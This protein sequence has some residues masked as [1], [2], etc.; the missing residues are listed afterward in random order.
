VGVGALVARSEAEC[1][2]AEGERWHSA[3][4][5]LAAPE[6]DWSRSDAKSVVRVGA[7]H[8]PRHTA[9]AWCLERVASRCQL[10]L[11]RSTERRPYHR[12]I[13]R[14]EAQ[15]GNLPFDL[16]DIVS[17]GR[18][19]ATSA[20]NHVAAHP[21]TMNSVPGLENSGRGWYARSLVSLGTSGTFPCLPHVPWPIRRGST[22]PALPS[23]PATA[24][25]S[26]LP[27]PSLCPLL[28]HACAA[29]TLALPPL[30]N[31]GPLAVWLAL[32]RA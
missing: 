9:S 1:L 12:D 18:R 7:P 14:E 15:N 3:D 31:A 16:Q 26:P 32:A 22:C 6:P 20:I 23:F 21:V 13:L 8:L 2:E 17:L 5:K 11:S 10:Q 30:P 4:G 19:C 27:L 25:L 29:V 28:C 24:P